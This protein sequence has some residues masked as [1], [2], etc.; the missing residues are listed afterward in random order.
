MGRRSTQPPLLP[1]SN[2]AAVASCDLTARNP[3]TL[4]MIN[5]N[6]GEAA[7][8][9]ATE[10][11]S[12]PCWLLRRLPIESRTVIRKMFLLNADSRPTL[13]QISSYPWL[14]LGQLCPQEDGEA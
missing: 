2:S 10:I 6:L 14:Q 3:D 4:S 11:D 7:N 5:I 8:M 12:E 13:E 1:A 9:K